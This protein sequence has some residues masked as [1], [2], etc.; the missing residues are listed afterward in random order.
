MLG[1][2]FLPATNF[3]CDLGQFASL[4][5]ISFSLQIVITTVVTTIYRTHTI[6]GYFPCIISFEPHTYPVISPILIPILRMRLRESQW[7]PVSDKEAPHCP[8]GP[9]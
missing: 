9:G 3:V 5:L 2:N 4:G 8:A 6:A 1:P 7:L